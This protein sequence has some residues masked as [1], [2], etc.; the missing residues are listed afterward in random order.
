MEQIKETLFSINKNGKPIQWACF[1]EDESYF[2]EHGQ[3]G[4]KLQ[5]KETVCKPKN[6]GKEN[7][8][9]PQEQAL[10]EAEARWTKQWVR[11]GYRYTVEEGIKAKEDFCMLAAD[12]RKNPHLAKYPCHAQPKLDGVRASIRWKGD[13]IIAMSRKLVE[14]DIHEDLKE[15]IKDLMARQGYDQLDGEFYIHGLL[16]QDIQSAVKSTDNE[17]HNKVK[18]HIFDVPVRN[19]S[20][21]CRSVDL[22]FITNSSVNYNFIEF[23]PFE[24]VTDE[25]KLEDL[26][27]KYEEQGYE[28]AIV[29]NFDGL[30]EY[31]FRSNDLIKFKNMKESEALVVGREKDD[32]SDEGKLICQWNGVEFGLKMM[33]SHKSRLYENL[34]QYI[35][36][37]ITFL[38]QNGL[39]RDG[40]PP[41]ARGKCVRECDE[42]GNPLV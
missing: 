24:E 19:I 5:L 20:W 9:T 40:K 8:T 37:W 28:G 15:E 3:V 10:K 1:V 32:K 14:Y 27:S 36:K 29:R 31:G 12:G 25:F 30:Y 42:D 33:G 4:G 23:V 21:F 13:D 11:E 16:L 7:E 17:D 35:G 2:M 39:T 22:V 6:V 18:F 41:F 26:V 38:Y 34:E